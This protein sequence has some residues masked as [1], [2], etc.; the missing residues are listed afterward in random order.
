MHYGFEN[1]FELWWIF[2]LLFLGM[3]M[4]CMFFMSRMSRSGMG[5]CGFAWRST[6]RNDTPRQD[7]SRGHTD[8]AEHRDFPSLPPKAG[9]EGR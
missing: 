5:C 7:T 8:T 6:R 2:P 9:G 1:G 3:M 4:F